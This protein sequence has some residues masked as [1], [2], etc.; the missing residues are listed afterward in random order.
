MSSITKL[1]CRSI[2]LRQATISYSIF[3]VRRRT[4]A[5]DPRAEVEHLAF[6]RYAGRREHLRGQQL[7]MAAGALDMY[8]V[9]RGQGRSGE[10][11][12]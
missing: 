3:N 6:R 7:V 12:A 5:P 2:E 4:P 8:E 10:R 9:P 11:G 1:R